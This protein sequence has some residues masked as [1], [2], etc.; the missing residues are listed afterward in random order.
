MSPA[1]VTSIV[2]R[3]PRRTCAP[4]GDRRAL[5][6]VLAATVALLSCDTFAPPDFGVSYINYGTA[7]VHV[8]ASNVSVPP[9]GTDTIMVALDSAIQGAYLRPIGKAEDSARFNAVLPGIHESTVRGLRAGCTSRSIALNDTTSV[10]GIDRKFIV[11]N[12]RHTA[13]VYFVSCPP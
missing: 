13:I 8:Q 7:T 10:A 2:H 12:G 4:A 1:T 11:E 6:A 9:Y 3:R 5:Q